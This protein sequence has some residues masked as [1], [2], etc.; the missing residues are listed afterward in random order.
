MAAP[1]STTDRT[2]RLRD[3]RSLGVLEA[4]SRDG[5]VIFHFHGHRSCRLEIQLI[6]GAA[7]QL[8][9]RLIGLDRP[10]IGRSDAKPGFQILDW[11]DDVRD[12]ADQL[13][14]K[15]FAVSGLSAGGIYALA[16]AYKIPQRL[17]A[18]GLIS[19]AVPGGYITRAGPRWMKATWFIGRRA[20][21]LLAPLMFFLWHTSSASEPKVEAALMRWSRWL[22]EEDQNVVADAKARA[23]LAAMVAENARQI[24]RTNIRE[25]LTDFRPWGFTPENVS[26]PNIFMWHGEDDR[27][28]PISLARMLARALPH[29]A[30][31]FYP[32]D[33]HFSVL[34]RHADGILRQLSKPGLEAG[35]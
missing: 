16:C 15:T 18:C 26:F 3:G 30:A 20:P 31:T 6:A 8:G 24:R 4:G 19:S 34:I 10:S 12:A 1:E 23:T 7:Q 33:G 25:A 27:M 35:R 22:C 11:P 2:L 14:I 28:M 9:I 32:R 17:T 13:G 29:C 5:P 21:L